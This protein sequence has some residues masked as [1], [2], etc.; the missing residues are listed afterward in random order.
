MSK[1]PR[2]FKILGYRAK[3]VS[4]TTLMI[5]FI[6]ALF[7]ICPRSS[8]GFSVSCSDAVVQGATQG[9]FIDGA[10][11]SEGD[12]QLGGDAPAIYLA[13][14][15]NNVPNFGNISWMTELALVSFL[16]AFP[17]GSKS[18]H[19]AVYLECY[20]RNQEEKRPRRYTSSVVEPMHASYAYEVLKAI[21]ALEKFFSSVEYFCT[22]SLGQAV[23]HS[24][25]MM[26]VPLAQYNAFFLLEHDWVILP[27]Q[28]TLNVFSVVEAL[29][30]EVEYI[31]M[32]RGD[33]SKKG[34]IKRFPGLESTD[35]YA[36]NPFFANEKFLRRIVDAG[37]CNHTL[38]PRW[39]RLVEKHCKRTNCSLSVMVTGVRGSG[40]YH[41]D[42]RYMSTAQLHGTG[43]IF[44]ELGEAT[45]QFLRGDSSSSEL[46][47]MIDAECRKLKGDCG[48]Y[49]HR[50]KFA[51]LL[52][53]VVDEHR[54]TGKSLDEI[55][56]N[57]TGIEPKHLLSGKFIGKEKFEQTLSTTAQRATNR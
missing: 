49:F 52:S 24:Y 57:F 9:K 4:Y 33:R 25:D 37:L 54:G 7:R 46:V 26:S 56:L 30:S 32:Q 23:C 6:A 51:E 8:Q 45:A 5:F 40:L 11:S 39:E 28:V 3:G 31:L 16:R 17:T 15:T 10:F 34:P 14:V 36:N 47:D 35:V 1:F 48:P 53:S 44:N 22:P 2:R 29:T 12:T 42:G 50:Y 13:F 27:S 43:P 21:G 41:M 38:E 55:I 18:V 20:T 19:L